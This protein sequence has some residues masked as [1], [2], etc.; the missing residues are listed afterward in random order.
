M[1]LTRHA[2]NRLRWIARRHETVSEAALLATIPAGVTVGYDERGN[3]RIRVT[4]GATRLILVIDESQG[5][6]ITMWAE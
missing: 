1:R 5:S 4:V 3:R 2:K 6:I